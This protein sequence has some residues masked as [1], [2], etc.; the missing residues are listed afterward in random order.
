MCKANVVTL[1]EELTT[2][3]ITIERDRTVVQVAHRVRTL[4]FARH[5]GR[6]AALEVIDPGHGDRA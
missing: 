3:T 1:H 6:A 2:T 5:G 4:R